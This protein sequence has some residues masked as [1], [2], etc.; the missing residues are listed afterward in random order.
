MGNFCNLAETQESGESDIF[1]GLDDYSFPSRGIF[2]VRA[3]QSSHFMHLD[4]S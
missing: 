2:K 3:V 4:R 1:D